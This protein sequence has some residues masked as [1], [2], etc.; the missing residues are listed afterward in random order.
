MIPRTSDCRTWVKMR[1]AS[2]DPT[3]PGL[4][5]V[6]DVPDG[7]NYERDSGDMTDVETGG[8][9]NTHACVYVS[10]KD[11]SAVASIAER[12]VPEVDRL[13]VSMVEECQTDIESKTP[14]YFAKIDTTATPTSKDAA[15]TAL[16]QAVL[17]GLSA[18][19]AENTRAT[20]GLPASAKTSGTIDDDLYQA[21]LTYMERTHGRYLALRQVVDD[22]TTQGRVS[23]GRAKEIVTP[24]TTT[25]DAT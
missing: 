3:C 21:K 24:N 22:Y 16:V 13:F 6:P 19:T 12:D 4:S 8:K 15:K 10:P 25:G 9:M 11:V 17:L 20:N 14:A 5:L 7:V 2:G 1:D 18:E 23:K